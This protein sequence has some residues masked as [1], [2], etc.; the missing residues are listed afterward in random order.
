MQTS[1]NVLNYKPEEYQEAGI[2]FGLLHHYHILGDEMG[3]GKTYQAIALAELVAKR[4]LIVCPSYLKFNWLAEL[5]K[6]RKLKDKNVKVLTKKADFEQDFTNT[7]YI[8]MSYSML[9]YAKELFAWATFVIA[10]EAH[11]LKNMLAQRTE[12]FHEFLYEGQPERCALLSGTPIQNRITEWFSLLKICSYSPKKTN[13]WDISQDFPDV[14]KFNNTFAKAR[15]IKIGGRTI[16][17]FEG[18]RNVDLL[19]KY[20]KL[21]YVRRLAKNVLDLKEM[22]PKYVTVDYKDDK[23]LEEAWSSNNSRRDASS[24]AKANSALLKSDYTAL[25]LKD[26]LAEGE[27][28]LVVFTDHLDSLRN[29]EKIL[30]K[31]KKLRLAVW[32][33]STPA[34]KRHE[35]VAAFQAGRKDIILCTIKSGNTGHNMTRA[36]HVIFN[37][38]S[39]VP[40]ENDQALKRIHRYGQ[41]KVCTAHYMIGSVQDK[42]IADSLEEKRKVLR[43]AM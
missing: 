32:D 35:M 42:M 16:T 41:D 9:K 23:E 7:K 12:Y 25:Y 18:M 4:T 20:L 11:Y 21:K 2:R 39:W 37:D 38:E 33:G 24:P 15:R 5:I 8:I 1:R 3:L 40:G 17:K 26:L 31:N 13:G 14:W 28:P 36:K 27:G 10:D 6:F 22:L 29:I 30:S 19:K 43:E 34:E